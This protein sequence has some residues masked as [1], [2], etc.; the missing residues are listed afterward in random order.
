MFYIKNPIL[1]G[2]FWR[3]LTNEFYGMVKPVLELKNMPMSALPVN[4]FVTPQKSVNPN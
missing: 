4:F 3:K 2:F 1:A